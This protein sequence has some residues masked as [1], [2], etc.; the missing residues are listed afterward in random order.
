[1]KLR[2]VLCTVLAVLLLTGCGAGSKP[3]ENSAA[4]ASFPESEVIYGEEKSEET[5]SVETGAAGAVS[6]V[7]Q[8][9]GEKIIRTFDLSIETKEF[10]PVYD[11]IQKKVTE[12][13]GYMEDSS[14]DIGSAY[15]SNYNRYATMTAR[16]PSDRLTEFVENVKDTANVTNISESTRN[17]TLQ[18]VD[19]ES[20]KKALETEQTRLLE[21]LE[22]AETVEDIITIEGRLSEVRYE[23]ESYASRLRTLDNQVDYSTVSISIHEVERETPAAPKGFWEQVGER[24]GNSVYRLGRNVKEA[25]IRFLGSL[26]FILVWAAFVVIVVFVIKIIRK[27]RKNKEK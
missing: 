4:D 11:G 24:F 17:V 13:G 27:K 10:D 3:S 18:Y 23:I 20:R 7:P 14:L 2:K 6:E 16:I 22:K 19:T 12:L 15:Y 26:P 25:A 5:S 8:D 9:A 1:M 21:L